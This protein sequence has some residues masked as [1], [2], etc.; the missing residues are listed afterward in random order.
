MQD[1]GRNCPADLLQNAAYGGNPTSELIEFAFIER[2]L[3][4]TM[5]RIHFFGKPL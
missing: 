3:S 1:P 2:A 5:M 4:T